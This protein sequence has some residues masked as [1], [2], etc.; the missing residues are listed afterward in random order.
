MQMRLDEAVSFWVC[1][2]LGFLGHEVALLASCH[3]HVLAL[4]P[5]SQD[6]EG[7][8]PEA[9]G[10]PAGVGARKSLPLGLCSG[11]RS[12]SFGLEMEGERRIY[13]TNGISFTAEP[14]ALPS[15]SITG[16]NFL[17]AA[18]QRRGG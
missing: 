15:T 13:V 18:T 14:Q 9:M 6:S 2:C 1:A 4:P 7:P 3:L 10:R 16:S 11:G 5:A 17:Q 8:G 12:F